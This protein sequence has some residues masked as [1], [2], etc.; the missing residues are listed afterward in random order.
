MNYEIEFSN[1]G[2]K[3][4]KIVQKSPLRKK[5]LKILDTLEKNPYAPIFEKLSGNLKNAYSRRLNQQ[6]RI[7][8]EIRENEKIINILSM[9]GHYDD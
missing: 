4:L 1:R 5:A 7:V 2:L 9:W 3:D 8:Y 6:H